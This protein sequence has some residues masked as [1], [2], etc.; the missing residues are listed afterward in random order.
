MQGKYSVG[1]ILKHFLF[2]SLMSLIN[3]KDKNTYLNLQ[4]IKNS[5]ELLEQLYIYLHQGIII[6]AE[7]KSINRGRCEALCCHYRVIKAWFS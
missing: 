2:L 6:I 5:W 4:Q 3:S 1:S 7:D